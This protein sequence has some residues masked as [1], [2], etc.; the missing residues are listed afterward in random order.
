MRY[1][2]LVHLTDKMP[3]YKRKFQNVEVD[4]LDFE[5]FCCRQPHAGIQFIGD[6][7]IE[8]NKALIEIA[9]E[10]SGSI[11][12]DI[13]DPLLGNKGKNIAVVYQP[14]NPIIATVPPTSLRYIPKYKPCH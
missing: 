13:V 3:D 2:D 14:M 1:N 9:E 8:Y 5:C 6:R 4:L 11:L 12:H 7:V 10:L